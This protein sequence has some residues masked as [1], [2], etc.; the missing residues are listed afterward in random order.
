MD[1]ESA[2]EEYAGS[3]TGEGLDAPRLHAEGLLAGLAEGRAESPAL[4][5]LEQDDD[6]QH[7]RREDEDEVERDDEEVHGD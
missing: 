7:Q 5:L 4:T 3:D 2:G 6:D 1:Q